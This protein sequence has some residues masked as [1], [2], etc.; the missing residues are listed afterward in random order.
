MDDLIPMERIES[1][2]YLIRG[3]KVMLD[4][5]LAELYGVSTKRLNEAVKRNSARFPAEF[6]FRLSEGEKSE[7]VANCDR[8]APLKHSTSLPYAFNE[9]GVAMLS[10]VLNNERAIRINILIIKAFVR[11]RNILSTHKELAD[12]I[13][14]LE[15]RV[16]QHD[17]VII[18]IVREIKRI[19]DIEEKPGPRIGFNRG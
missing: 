2:I 14:A 4:R 8:F 15:N 18:E 3:Q 10:S 13:N 1:R 5:D 16:G 11:L 9:H 12:R 19:I 6:M 7:L 17:E